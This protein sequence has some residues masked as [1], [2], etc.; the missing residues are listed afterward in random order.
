MPCPVESLFQIARLFPFAATPVGPTVFPLMPCS[1]GTGGMVTLGCLA[2]GFSPSTLTFAW[3]KGLTA[4]ADSIQ[5]PSIQKGDRYTG[6]SQIQVSSADWEA[7]E[8]FKCVAQHAAGNGDATFVKKGRT[9]P[10][11]Y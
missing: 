10:L 2:T 9:S 6:V 5:Y 4:L 8:Q 7:K 11:L 1:S 3:T